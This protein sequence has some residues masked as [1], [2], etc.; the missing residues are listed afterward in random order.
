[1]AIMSVGLLCRRAARLVGVQWSP[2][3][4][5]KV[6]AWHRDP[7]NV[8]VVACRRGAGDHAAGL[9]TG[10]GLYHRRHAEAEADIVP[11]L[12]RDT[13]V[14]WAA[15]QCG[16]DYAEQ[17]VIEGPAAFLVNVDFDVDV[18]EREEIRFGGG[19][20]IVVR[21]RTGE[22]WYLAGDPESAFVHTAKNDR[23]LR[24]AITK[25]VPFSNRPDGVIP[26]AARPPARG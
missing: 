5:M 23:R 26:G 9:L 4:W 1:M 17:R 20:S 21:K 14:A 6:N 15:D 12:T 16:P 19:S 3:N 18:A 25:I 8:A 13:V 7:Q 2:A 11:M 24:R 22:F 10:S